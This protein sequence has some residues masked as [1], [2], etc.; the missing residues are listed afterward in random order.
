M[1]RHSGKARSI[2]HSRCMA[3]KIM[4]I[5]IKIKKIPLAKPDRVSMRPYLDEVEALR[6]SDILPENEL[7]HKYTSRSVPMLP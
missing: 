1:S 7:T 2:T 6:Q 4:N 5:E 3:S